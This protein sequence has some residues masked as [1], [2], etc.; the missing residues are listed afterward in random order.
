MLS[1]GVFLSDSYSLDSV[2]LKFPTDATL[3]SLFK[4]AAKMAAK[5][6]KNE[7]II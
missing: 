2:S 1:Q 5:F 4:I 6:A 3:A 7:N